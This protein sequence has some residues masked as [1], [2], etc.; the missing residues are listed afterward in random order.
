VLRSEVPRRQHRRSQASSRRARAGRRRPES[1]VARG[2]EVVGVVGIVDFRHHQFGL[3]EL[4]ASV[5]GPFGPE[6]GNAAT[7]NLPTGPDG[8]TRPCLR[9]ALLLVTE[10]GG[11]RTALFVRGPEP[12]SGMESV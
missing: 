7:V 5:R 4:A 3:A 1:A 2:T 6:P 12:D 9:C 8:E 11:A 10:P